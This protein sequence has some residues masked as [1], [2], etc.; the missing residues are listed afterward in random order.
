MHGEGGMQSNWRWSRGCNRLAAWRRVLGRLWKC[1]EKSNHESLHS[2]IPRG[3]HA[4]RTGS[5]LQK[6]LRK[7]GVLMWIPP[8]R[9]RRPWYPMKPSFL[10]LFIKKLTRDRVVPIMVASVAC[11]IPANPC[12]LL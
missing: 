5:Y 6:A 11:D 12:G 1:V 9:S 10:N 3:R 4:E 2:Q 8:F 7:S